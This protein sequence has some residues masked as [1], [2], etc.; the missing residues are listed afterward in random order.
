MNSYLHYAILAVSLGVPL[1]GCAAAH[2]GVATSLLQPLW[3]TTPSAAG[4]TRGREAIE[5][6]RATVEDEREKLRIEATA[7]FFEPETDQ[8]R[9]RLAG[10]IAGM[11]KAYQAFPN[12][13]NVATPMPFHA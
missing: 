10:W 7:A 11:E 13:L 1:P 9:E 8:V 2:W 6:A 5:K 12:D 4:I 3:G